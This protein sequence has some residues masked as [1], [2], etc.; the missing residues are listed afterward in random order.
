MGKEGEEVTRAKFLHVHLGWAVTGSRMR[1]RSSQ[2]RQRCQPWE[3]DGCLWGGLQLN[4]VVEI[5][6]L[7]Q[8]SQS[9]AP[10]VPNFSVDFIAYL[11]ALLNR[12]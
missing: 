2:C 3:G 1:A 11:D 8:V 12:T 10:S 6:S 7:G 9:F 5:A 4:L